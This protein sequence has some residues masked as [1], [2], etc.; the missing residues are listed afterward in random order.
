MEVLSSFK[1]LIMNPDRVIFDGNASTVFLPGDLGE[2][3]ILPFHYPVLSRLRYG[4]I[5]IDWKYAVPIDKGVLRFFKNEC[6][7]VCELRG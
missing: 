3:E 2:F 5:L 6:V 1:L 7:I 4:E